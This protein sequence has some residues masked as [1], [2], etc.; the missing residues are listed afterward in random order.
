MSITTT[1]VGLQI[2]EGI[3]AGITSFKEPSK[4]NIGL[5]M[6]RERGVPGKVFE[7]QTLDDDK[8]Y[9]G[10]PVA[11]TFGGWVMKALAKNADPA[12]F[13][14]FAT[15]IVGSTSVA[16]TGTANLVIGTPGVGATSTITITTLG[17]NGDQITIRFGLTIIAAFV[18][19]AAETTVNLLAAAI[20]GVINGNTISNGFSA[21]VVGA[22]VTV[23]A[24]VGL[25]ATI[26]GSVLTLTFTGTMA[27]TPV[28]FS[29]GVTAI[30][31]VTAVYTAA[32]RGDSDPGT[33][34]NNISCKLYSFDYKLRGV[35]VLEI[36]YKGSIVETFSEIT[37]AA[38]QT[39]VNKRSGYVKVTFNAEWPVAYTNLTGTVTGTVVSPTIAG[40]GTSFTSE[41]AVGT[42]L[43]NA[44]GT[45]IGRVQS[46]ESNTS[47]TLQGNALVAITASTA[48]KRADSAVTAALAMGTYVSPVE[49][50]FYPVHST[51]NPKG[52]ALLDGSNIQLVAVTEF[53]TLTMA[54]QLQ[55]YAVEREDCIA[56]CQLPIN[57]DEQ[58]IE[59]FATTLQTA[60]RNFICGYAD[61]DNVYNTAGELIT[62]P[63]IGR[64]LGAAFIRTPY[65]QGDHIHIPPGG[66]DSAAKDLISL[67]SGA[68]SQS[69][70]NSYVRNYHLNVSQFSDNYG[71]Y[72][73]SSRMY[74]TN[75]LYKSIHINMQTNFYVR[76][77][78]DN[79]LFVLQKPNTPQLKKEVIGR[80]TEYFQKEY[81]HGAL[82]RS[83]SF[84]EAFKV[85]CDQTNNPS[86]QDR[87]VLNV[88]IEYIPTECTESVVIALNR[89]DALL[90]A[91][92]S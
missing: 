74:C 29:G 82:E 55:T 51:S 70:I 86:G 33:W 10:D 11:T 48:K 35:Y 64:I 47:L 25:G 19:T 9:F 81:E 5:L 8:K 37:L 43:Y 67:A 76:I 34:G 39:T 44:V 89:N 7:V 52:L 80:V 65:L 78:L 17:S 59:L 57:A 90:T 38:M 72:M 20:A 66:I 16:A 46:I 53:H 58:I 26:N 32:Y 15:R 92:V 91:K 28:G 75:D 45:F 24:P 83:V 62:I 6:E 85:T 1:N 41:V 49:A 23:T 18:K 30:A 87:K 61:W 36:L 50:D 79:L 14:I 21:S 22:V 68:Y 63:G 71:R 77:L 84:E 13:R 40:V 27:G 73:L 56:I 42:Q 3:S 31:S 2:T 60:T 88:Q 12:P 4:R 54:Q 69:Q